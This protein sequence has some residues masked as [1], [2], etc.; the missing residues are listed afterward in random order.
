MSVIDNLAFKLGGNVNADLFTKTAE[1]IVNELEKDP[2]AFDKYGKP[3]MDKNKIKRISTTQ[4]RRFYNDLLSIKSQMEICGHSERDE[5]F[6]LQIPYI[7]ML[8]TKARYAH[9][10]E[11]AGKKFINF[12]EK[13]LA[14]LDPA[15][16][17]ESREHFLLFCSLFE[18]VIAYSSEKLGKK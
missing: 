8:I 16:P 11:H 2:V 4:I 13:G 3:K 6:R 5:K 1:E 7:N 10:R 9:S 14:P 12:M 17:K 18:A 15:K